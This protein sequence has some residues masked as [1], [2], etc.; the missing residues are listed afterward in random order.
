MH[1]HMLALQASNL[2]DL[3]RFYAHTLNFAV[4]GFTESQLAVRCGSSRL[5]FNRADEPVVPA[6]FA[7]NIAEAHHVEVFGW[8]R[9]RVDF[10][11]LDGADEFFSTDWNAHMVYA[12][13]PAGNIIEFI[14]RHTLVD[15]ATAGASN[16]APINAAGLAS[17]ISE[18]GIACDDVP[19]TARAW[20][21]I[22]STSA[23]GE[24]NGNFYPI[25]DEHGLLIIVPKG[26]IWFPNTGVA[27]RAAPVTAHI[28]AHVLSGPPYGARS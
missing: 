1:I 7:F 3:H 28:D 6:H 23:Y 16:D 4:D 20:S 5:I 19:A 15:G 24:T 10:I 12:C 26:R 9:A 14:A 8:L 11:A 22:F 17:C 25:G 27:A 18:I 13:D 21:Q 2:S